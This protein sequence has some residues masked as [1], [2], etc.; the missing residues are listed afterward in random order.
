MQNGLHA[1]NAVFTAEDYSA[2]QAGKF[3][4][5]KLLSITGCQHSIAD[6]VQL[7]DAGLDEIVLRLP[8]SHRADG[9]IPDALAY[10]N[11][12]IGVILNC[13]H[14]AGIRAYQMDNEP[15][16]TWTT[17]EYGPWQYQWW[18]KRVVSI[19]KP[20]VPADVVLIAPPLSFAP[21]LWTRGPQ[22]PTEL[23]LDD[24]LA[25]YQWT[26]AHRQTSLWGVFTQASANCYW[27]S[28][29]QMYDPSF[30]AIYDQVHERSGGMP[31]CVTEWA[32]SQ[33]ELPNQTTE[34]IEAARASQYPKWLRAAKDAGYVTSAFLYI[35]PGATPDWQ[36]FVPTARVLTS[37]SRAFT[38]SDVSRIVGGGRYAV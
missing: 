33:H 4:A 27:Q 5:S 21:A 7:R 37:V 16:W 31:V 24:W 32:S 26:D 18:I 20:S 15:N 25:A 29:K 3:T 10:A 23:I 22:N 6:A 2:L 30:G 8:D 1:P 13:Y 34:E 9:T 36:G 14:N 28:E 19:V 35:S 11:G 17:R 12:C 38:H